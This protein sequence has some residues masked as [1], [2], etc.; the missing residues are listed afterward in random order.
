MLLLFLLAIV[1]T[2]AQAQFGYTIS[3]TNLIITNYTGIGGNVTIPTTIDGVPVTIIGNYAFMGNTNLTSVTIPANITIIGS[4]AFDSCSRLTNATII[5]GAC[6]SCG[7]RVCAL[8][9][10]NSVHHFSLRHWPAG[11]RTLHQSHQCNLV[12]GVSGGRLCIR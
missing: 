7:W 4:G 1:S 11:V 3:G 2:A 5:G 8:L 10:A 9:G 6:Q 12:W